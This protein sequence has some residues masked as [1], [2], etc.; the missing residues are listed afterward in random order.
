MSWILDLGSRWQVAN[1]IKRVHLA[2]P[3]LSRL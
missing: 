3:I 1:M 2:G